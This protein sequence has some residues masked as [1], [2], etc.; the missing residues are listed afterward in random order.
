MASPW[1]LPP[2]V[3][4]GGSK[5]QLV[6]LLP[7]SNLDSQ[8]MAL[9]SSD[10]DHLGQALGEQQAFPT[11]RLCPFPLL[12]LALSRGSGLDFASWPGTCLCVSQPP[13][14]AFQ[15]AMERFSLPHTPQ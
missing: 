4:L 5:A 12:A 7:T 9:H 3:P 10:S 6:C 2:R 13:W 14:D 1:P 11:S 15:P 8:E